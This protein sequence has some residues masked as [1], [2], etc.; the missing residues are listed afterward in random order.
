MCWN[1]LSAETTNGTAEG[2]SALGRF[3]SVEIQARSR[4]LVHGEPGVSTTQG[5]LSISGLPT[6]GK[7]VVLPRK[8]ASV[9]EVEARLSSLCG[10]PRL[11]FIPFPCCMKRRG[12]PVGQTPVLPGPGWARG[13]E[14]G[15]TMR[16]PMTGAPWIP[17]PRLREGRPRGNDKK[18]VH[19]C[20]RVLWQAVARDMVTFSARELPD[21]FTGKQTA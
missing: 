5:A 1:S 19:R 2:S 16:G 20:G 4:L 14:G 17:A 12:R 7:M 10:F 21:M 15:T 11:A 13:H 8:I 9:M 18:R 3:A 6:S